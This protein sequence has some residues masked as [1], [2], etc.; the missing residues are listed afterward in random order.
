MEESVSLG[1]IYHQSDYQLIISKDETNTMN[2]STH[3]TVAYLFQQFYQHQKEMLQVHEQYV[4]TQSQ[5]FQAF[6][7]LLQQQE[8]LIPQGSTSAIA[9]QTVVVPAPV[10]EL[11]Q[12]PVAS[13]VELPKTP[14][15]PVVES[16][17]VTPAPVA[18]PVHI[19][20]IAN[21]LEPRYSAPTPQPTLVVTETAS[22]AASESYISR[23]LMEVVS[24]KTGYPTE[25][26]ELEMDLEADL[27]VD[28]IKRVEIMG[29]LH[30]SFPQ[31]PKL[32]PEELAEKRTLAQ[33]VQYLAG[34][35]MVAEKKIA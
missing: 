29:T 3:N 14:V 32:S 26:L 4:K 21:Y 31:L 35:I 10:V 13:V 22:P 6:L 23:A 33:I 5:S 19:S 16:P 28:S 9:E 20:H 11:P 1:E 12:T 7:Q 30:E 18:E 27:G 2:N 25:M 34:Q 8:V 17:K 15:A 24:D